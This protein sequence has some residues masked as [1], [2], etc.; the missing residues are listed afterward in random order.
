[1]KNSKFLISIIALLIHTQFSF[2][3]PGFYQIQAGAFYYSPNTLEVE[4]GSTITW[5][6]V[7]GL[8]DVNFI[9]NSITDE[10]FN[11]PESFS[12]D[13]VYSSGPDNP[14]EIG[15]WTFDIEGTY[16]YDCSI[17][18][19][20]S[21]GMV[22]TIIV[23]PQGEYPGCMDPVA[24]NY[25]SVANIDDNSC[26]YDGNCCEA[27]T[28]ECLACQACQTPEEWCLDNPGFIGC[29]EYDVIGCMDDGLQVWSPF[30][31]IAADDYEPGA[32]TPGDCA[33]WGCGILITH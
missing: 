31:G 12:I 28:P 26:L 19:H 9:I 22:G 27:L 11:N 7:G 10:S 23:T 6:N 32:N 14:V 25:S 8:H 15:S 30:P 33:Y 21:Q 17:G 24:C 4:A 5:V 29:D 3:Q 2:G 1:M 18:S 13:P 20:A 16:Q